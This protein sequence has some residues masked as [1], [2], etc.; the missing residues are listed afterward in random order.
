MSVQSASNLW[1]S[2]LTIG[3]LRK[4]IVRIQ[5]A[6]P[7]KFQRLEAWLSVVMER[8]H[9]RTLPV[10]RSVWLT[11]ADLSGEAM[12]SGRGVPSMDAL[13]MATAQHHDLV[14]VTRN[15]KDFLQY[16]KLLNPWEA[17]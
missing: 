12:R 14:I 7:L 9:A 13:L 16:P 11:W 1:I 5:L 2:D 8:F 10:D 4:G 17:S 6:D 3:E 15:T